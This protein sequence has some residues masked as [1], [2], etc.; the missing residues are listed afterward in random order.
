VVSLAVAQHVIKFLINAN[1]K[2]AENLMRL[3]EQFGYEMPSRTQVYD[4]TKS[5]KEGW[6]E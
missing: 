4:W 5:F 2:P 6:T 3:R 1:I